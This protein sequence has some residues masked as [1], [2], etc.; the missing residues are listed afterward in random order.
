MPAA[1]RSIKHMRE[2]V[3]ALDREERGLRAEA[4]SAYDKAREEKRGLSESEKARDGEIKARLGAIETDRVALAEEVENAEKLAA[5]DASTAP[6]AS[7]SVKAMSDEDPQRGFANFAEFAL[8]VHD[9][10]HGTCGV[11][12]NPRLMAAAG[13]GMTQ[14]V[15]AD[16]GV[17]VPPAFAT[18]IWDGARRPS[19]SML[20]Y[21][22]VR[23]IDAGVQSLEFPGLN[24][25]S[26]ANGSRW[27]GIQ[28]Y[29]KGELS[30]LTSSKP[31]YRS[32]KVE[33]QELY[34]FAYVSDKLLRH[35]PQAAS[36]TLARA[37]ADEINFKLGDA[38]FN[39]DGAGKPRGVIGH[40]SVVSISKETGQAAATITKENID[41]MWARC[42][43]S[44]RAGAVWFINQDV[45]PQLEQLVATVGTGGVPVYLPAGGVTEAPNARLKG[46]P[47]VPVEYCA[48]LGTVGDIVLAN[49]SAYCMGIRGMVDQAQSMHLKFDYAQTAFRF[50]F[51]ADG[52]PW[53]ASTLTPFK[54]TNTLSPI[55]T[56]ATR[57]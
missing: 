48:T 6:R 44:W 50:I 12:S 3:T 56:L 25:T 7:I 24:E 45:E 42:H 41:K 18:E 22:D 40:A 27:G 1:I 28:G 26:R 19:E 14:G 10:G 17:L 2:D 15:T 43:A 49:F 57:A 55:V 30:S 53:L 36:Q 47:V 31:A 34:V 13:T 9:A 39:G 8:A 51:E 29:W 11:F 20:Q 38:V 33:P 21:C 54:G 16:G 46:R 37:A 52:Q 23:T 32:V 35:A 5:L 4:K